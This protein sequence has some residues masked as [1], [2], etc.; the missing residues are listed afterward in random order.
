LSAGEDL[1]LIGVINRREGGTYPPVAF[2]VLRDLP[3]WEGGWLV[4]GCD[5]FPSQYSFEEGFG[6]SLLGETGEGL[7]D[8]TLIETINRRDGLPLSQGE[9]AV[10]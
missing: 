6:F 8:L 2:G 5:D 1:T 3:K 9:R 10:C 4:D 7:F